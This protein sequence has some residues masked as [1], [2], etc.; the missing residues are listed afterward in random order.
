MARP[1]KEINQETF[2]ELCKIHCTEEEIAQVLRVSVKTL[3]SWCKE[4]YGTSFSEVFKD[5]QGDG[6]ASLRRIQFKLAERNATMA[7][8]LGKQWLGQKD[9]PDLSDN[10]LNDFMSS[11]M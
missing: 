10:F 2:E 8:F 7:I 3:Y 1:K 5:F 4:T 9:N 11:L 6:K